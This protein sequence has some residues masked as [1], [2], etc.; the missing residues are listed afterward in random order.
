MLVS[1]PTYVLTIESKFREPLGPCGQMKKSAAA[2]SGNH[3]PGSDLRTRTNAPCRLTIQEGQRTP[4]LYWEVGKR[5]FQ[6]EV[7]EVPRPCPFAGGH[8]QLMRNMTFAAAFA[9]RAGLK[10]FGFIVAYVAAASSAKKHTTHQVA[11]F[12]NML[13]PELRDRFGSVS[14]ESISGIVRKRGDTRLA[15][16]IDVRLGDGLAARYSH[17]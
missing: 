11:E 6:P 3:A 12:K 14:Y 17:D 2:C 7:L 15:E 13:R 4:R 9:D 1:W 8:Y 10:D 16:C 5:V